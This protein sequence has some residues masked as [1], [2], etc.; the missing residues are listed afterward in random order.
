M[1]P[2]PEH[3][4]YQVRRPGSAAKQVGPTPCLGI[5]VDLVVA[6]LLILADK[7]TRLLAAVADWDT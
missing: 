5:E 2:S 3:T 1:S 6:E 7:L 4:H